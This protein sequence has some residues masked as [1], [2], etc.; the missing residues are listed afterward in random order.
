MK[1]SKK[2]DKLQT[3]SLILFLVSLGHCD[4]FSPTFNFL[5]I[6]G[7]YTA[8]GEYYD[9][10]NITSPLVMIFDDYRKV[11]FWSYGVALTWV[12]ENGTYGTFAGDCFYS[13]FN[14]DQQIALFDSTRQIGKILISRS[15]LVN[16]Y[17]GVADNAFSC[18]SGAITYTE[19][20]TFDSSPKVATFVFI[21]YLPS[22]G[23]LTEKLSIQRYS[24]YINTSLYELPSSC[25]NPLNYCDQFYNPF[26][27]APC[28][29]MTPTCLYENCTCA[30]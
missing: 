13:T 14:Y 12:F 22:V 7:N 16:Q 30:A 23:Y 24:S 15:G 4:I 20:T 9:S 11:I 27:R 1:R 25:Y 26:V 18:H 5:N 19:M 10:A 3:F 6:R 8:Y 2:M 29:G 21:T 17:L 28:F